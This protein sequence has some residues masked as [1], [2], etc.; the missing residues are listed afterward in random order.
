MKP[1]DF[2]EIRRLPI[3][4][5]S[6]LVRTGE[7]ATV[8]RPGSGFLEFLDCFPKIK[9]RTN[10]AASLAV[11]IDRIAEAVERECPVTWA[12]GP[13][14]IKYGLTPLI[15]ELMEM[16]VIRHVLTNGAGAIHD[17]EIAMIGET[18]EEM[19]GHIST[20]E[21]GMAEET[22]RF[23]NGCARHAAENGRGFGE[24]IGRKILD[25]NLPYAPFSL[26]AHAVKRNIPIT[27][28][29]A[30]GTDIIHMHPDMDGSATGTA[31]FTDFRLFVAT[32]RNLSGGVH[33]NIGS[34]VVLPEVFVKALTAANNLNRQ[35]ARDYTTVNIDHLSEYR[36][37][38]NVVRRGAMDGGE[39]YEIIGRMEILVPLL[40]RI[41][42]ERFG[43]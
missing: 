31:S 8:P 21:F 34:T 43:R 4:G 32:V 30:L 38:M 37:L 15:V 25:D 19:G 3:A 41:L 18:S 29:V 40:V 7:F 24:T 6:N 26:F 2:S 36:P 9:H 14:V 33:L 27:V 23:I 28:H 13:H 17:V 39:G 5:R 12:L 20:G 10:A 1:A 16:G 42:M 11:V 22:G 35:P